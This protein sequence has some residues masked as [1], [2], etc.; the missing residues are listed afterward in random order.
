MYR[1]RSNFP[2]DC[3]K[4]L[5]KAIFLSLLNYGN[6]IYSQAAATT[7]KPLDSSHHSAIR[8]I[9]G[10]PTMLISASYI[11]KL[12][13]PLS[14]RGGTNTFLLFS[15]KLLLDFYH[16]IYHPYWTGQQEFTKAARIT[17]LLSNTH[18]LN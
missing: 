15:I 8:F 18:G 5:V 7:L 6:R 4:G 11:I 10:A 2:L 1:S 17:L 12:V 16:H 14:H 9:T 3:R 13:G